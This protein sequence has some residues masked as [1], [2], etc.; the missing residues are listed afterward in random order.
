[1]KF[2]TFKQINDEFLSFLSES[3][4]GVMIMNQWFPTF[5]YLTLLEPL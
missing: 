1:M 5:L 2:K 3:I 4:P